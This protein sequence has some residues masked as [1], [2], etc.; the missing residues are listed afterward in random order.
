[1]RPN[2]I[3]R[4]LKEGKPAFGCFLNIPSIASA[5]IM[6]HVGWDWLVVDTEHGAIGV[7]TMHDMFIAIGTTDTVPM[8]RVRE[9]HPAA[10]KQALDAGAYGVVIPMVNSPEEAERAVK[11]CKYAPEGNRSAGPG[12]WRFYGGPDYQKFANDEVL[13]AIQIE[14]IDAVNR[15]EEILSVP[16]IDLVH[17]GPGDLAWSMGL[18]KGLGEKDPAHAEAV[19]KVVRAAKKFGVPIGTAARTVQQV[20]QLLEQGFTFIMVMNDVNFL[21]NSA[22]EALRY[23]KECVNK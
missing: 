14:H 7:D 16:G 20:P 4:L 13:V 2:R 17:M 10:I 6:A 9:N 1:M 22:S 23:S 11:A 12:R 19:A 18:G 21:F 3:K 15:V 5:E 8:C